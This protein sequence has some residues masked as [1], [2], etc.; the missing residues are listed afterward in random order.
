[1]AEDGYVL[2]VDRKKDMSLSGGENISSLEGE[3][4]LAAHPDAYEAA[5]IPVP[6]ECWGE[7]PKALVVVRPGA[8]VAESDVLEFCRGRIAHYKCPKSVEFLDALPQAR[9]RF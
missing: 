5:V 7:V 9:A 3:K 1:M 2:I 6:S 4:V 8:S